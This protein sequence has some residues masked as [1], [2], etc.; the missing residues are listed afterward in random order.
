MP[1]RDSAEALGLA[2]AIERVAA[3]AFPAPGPLANES[4][5][6]GLEPER[7][8]FRVHKDGRPGNRLG[9]AEVFTAFKRLAESD[10]EAGLRL[11]GPMPPIVLLPSGGTLT[12]EPGGQ[13]EHST[14]V[15]PD[16]STA[17]D[18][19]H[20]VADLIESAFASDPDTIEMVSLGLDPWHTAEDVPQQ[21]DHGRYRSMAAYLESRGPSGAM[22]MRLSC[23]LQVNVDLG[24]GET[25]KQRWD[26][27]NLLSPALVASFSTSPELPGQLRYHCRR[28]RV[29]QTIDETRSGIPRRFLTEPDAEP[30]S[31]YADAVLD[32]DVLLFRGADVK[33]SD[34]VPGTIGFRFRDWIEKGHPDHGWPTLD[35]LDYHLTT[36]F[37][38]VRARGFLELRGIDALPDC[39]RP[40]AT[41]FVSGLMYDDTAREAALGLIGEWR[42]DLD[43]RWKRSAELGHSD[44]ELSAATRDLWQLALD[45]C[46]RLGPEFLNGQHLAEA[47]AYYERFPKV[48]RA[49]ACELREALE[50]GPS[51][52]L[53]WAVRLGCKDARGVG[54]RS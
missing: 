13:I 36:L 42:G 17:L 45:G 30:A 46:A 25:R 41:A 40:A 4:R 2:A 49:P 28:A 18:D 29:W 7:F 16:A 1:T 53:S 33:G 15:H 38:E 39:W 32:A 47:R 26:L 50:A 27:S 6:V 10:P 51:E 35:D 12:F 24:S 44:E 22:M 19:V 52:A 54:A 43:Q 48:G 11:T 20:R 3:R 31:I 5:Q 23:S 34:A 8:G 21:L 9:L 37:F 14:A